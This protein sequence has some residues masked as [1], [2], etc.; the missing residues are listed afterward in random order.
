MT[1]ADKNILALDSSTRTLKL[2]LKFG[3]DRLVKSESDAD[4]S[5]G[6]IIIK[7]ISDLLSSAG[8]KQTDLDAIIVSIGPG[9]FTGLRIGLAAAKGI[10]LALQI[11]VASV[12]SFEIARSK[13]SDRTE[14]IYAVT[15]LT[16]DQFFVAAV[17]ETTFD[18]STIKVLSTNE[19]L[20][21]GQHSKLV[22]LGADLNNIIDDK[23][24]IEEPGEIAFDA[25][26]LLAL[27]EIKL[28]QNVVADLV[29]L[30]PLY[31]Q[32]SQAEIRF[33]QRHKKKD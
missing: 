9:S 30:E 10:A 1:Y 3:G 19:L 12:S 28:N 11:P 25:A 22:G 8:L 29:N 17:S 7:R 18:S 23:A 26:D 13:L 16:K 4:Q 6:Q 15:P 32:K 21:L 20:E 27:G 14:S 2:A 33:E 31:L 5:H 24:M